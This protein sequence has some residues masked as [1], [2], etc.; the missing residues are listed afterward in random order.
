MQDRLTGTDML[1]L[2][3]PRSLC[4]ASGVNANDAS[5]LAPFAAAQRQSSSVHAMLETNISF[6]PQT[7]LVSAG[8]E[9]TAAA[10]GRQPCP[11]PPLRPRRRSAALPT[12]PVLQQWPR[13]DAETI[14]VN[15][16][17]K[18]TNET[19]QRAALPLRSSLASSTAVNQD[20]KIPMRPSRCF[21]VEN[22]A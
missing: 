11:V 9:G 8:L 14:V 22:H 16:P 13:D 5:A 6:W 2:P 21:T 12:A 10:R 19:G 17:P 18:Q 20:T 15:L 4:C 7:S 1:P 3:L